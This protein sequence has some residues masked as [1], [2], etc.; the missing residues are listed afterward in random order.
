MI[1]IRL[2]TEELKA[3]KGSYNIAQ[4]HIFINREF[5]DLDTLE[6]KDFRLYFH[7]LYHHWQSL[8]TSYGQLKWGAYRTFYM[9]VVNIWMSGTEGT[10]SY[11]ILPYANLINEGSTE[12]SRCAIQLHLQLNIMSL[13]S[14]NERSRLSNEIISLLNLDYERLIPKVS[15]EGIEYDLNGLDIIETY[16]KYQEAMFG[17]LMLDVPFEETFNLKHLNKEYYFAYLYFIDKLKGA[18]EFEFPAICELALSGGN[19][20]NPSVDESW[21]SNHI[22]WR[23]IRISKCYQ[24]IKK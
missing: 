15:I 4:Q 18:R 23:F 17:F 24:N 13:L 7:E 20:S 11:R 3:I 12:F 19:F 2:N 16:A 5:L 21:F 10:G 9:D 6:T 14:L 22:G 1:Y 8:F